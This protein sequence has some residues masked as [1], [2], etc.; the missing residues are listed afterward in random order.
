MFC[1]SF[2]KFHENW[3]SC[4]S[5]ETI[6]AE[7]MLSRGRR[8]AWSS[9]GLGSPSIGLLKAVDKVNSKSRTSNSRIKTFFRWQLP[10]P[11]DPHVRKFNMESVSE[12]FEKFFIFRKKYERWC[13]IDSDAMTRLWDLYDSGFAYPLKERDD[14]G[15]GIIFMQAKK[16][17]TDKFTSADAVRQ[18]GLIVTTLMEEEATQISG[19]STIND[20]MDDGNNFFKLFLMRDVM[21]C[22]WSDALNKF[23]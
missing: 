10:A 6:E 8:N 16:L 23:Y 14:E 17:D 1:N 11:V 9:S 21:S 13:N 12:S 3:V 22:G 18:L 7:L 20:Y 2:S 5:R 15:K 4:Q 19:I